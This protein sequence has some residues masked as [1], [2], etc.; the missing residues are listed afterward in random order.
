MA[1]SAA[2][3]K[4]GI[5]AYKAGNKAQAE[6]F[7]RQAVDLDQYSEQGWLWLSAVVDTPEDR[8]T[9]LENVLAIN[10]ANDAA[11]KGLQKLD[12]ERGI[13]PLQPPSAGGSS[14]FTDSDEWS[15]LAT[16]SPSSYFTPPEITSK[17]YDDWVNNLG[18]QGK[19]SN[20]ADASTPFA[21]PP[22]T[23]AFTGIDM[24]GDDDDVYTS[25]PFDAAAPVNADLFQEDD[26]F[27]LPEP[28]PAPAPTARRMSPTPTVTSP[29]PGDEPMRGSAR[30]SES[31]ALYDDDELG[32]LGGDEDYLEYIP[33]DIV[34]TRL[35]GTVERQPLILTLALALLVLLN[36]GAVALLV[37]QL[38]LA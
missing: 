26:D 15:G 25:G 2:L 28:E 18:I 38:V 27:D 22:I 6:E 5:T 20:P 14:P 23:P 8:R 29:S 3:V 16:S 37:Y 33:D 36:V 24:F 12:E 9:C 4:E 11:R 35:P 21:S 7:F 34:A 30:F 17:D 32:E 1:E 19:T 31:T 13:T 10:P